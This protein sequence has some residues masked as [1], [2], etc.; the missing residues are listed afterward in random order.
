MNIDLADLLYLIFAFSG[1]ALAIWLFGKHAV[2]VFLV[3]LVA[4][5]I[6]HFVSSW[7]RIDYNLTLSVIVLL[8]IIG[9]TICFSRH[10]KNEDSSQLESD[11]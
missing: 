11:D 3:P 10:K 2:W 6:A 1:I 5:L 7:F 9:S 8:V 4:G